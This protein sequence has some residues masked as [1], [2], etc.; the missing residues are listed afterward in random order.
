MLILE[1]AKSNFIVGYFLLRLPINSIQFF[2][3]CL[4]SITLWSCY[5]LPR[6]HHFFGIL[7][8]SDVEALRKRSLAKKIFYNGETGYVTYLRFSTCGCHLFNYLV[9]K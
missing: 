9:I 1:Y 2:C 8:N 4:L 6:F 5:F 3:V 7:G